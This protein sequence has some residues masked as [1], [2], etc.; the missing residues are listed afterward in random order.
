MSDRIVR[1]F[2][3]CGTTRTVALAISKAF[4]RVWHADLLN[5]RKSF[6]VFISSFLNNGRLRV[7][8]N[9]KSSQGY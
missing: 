4:E 3:W 1:A 9:R 6:E 2:N 8:V 5:K 7:V